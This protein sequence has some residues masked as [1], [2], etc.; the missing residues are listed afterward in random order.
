MEIPLR[1]LIIEDSEDDALLIV[2]QLERAGYKLTNERVETREAA[3]REALERQTW[4]IIISDYKMPRFSGIA[5]LKL[6]KEKGLDIPFIIVSGTIGEEIAAEAM[7]SGAHDYVMKNNLPRLIPAIQRELREAES[8]RERK[9]AEEA[10]LSSEQKYRTLL[11]NASDAIMI[12]DSDGNFLE[13]NKKAEELL[14]YTREEVL[15]LRVSQVHPKEELERVLHA[16]GEIVE[17]KI[18]SL[19]DTKV[20]RKD[21]KTVPVD[22]TGTVIE[23]EGRRV[24]Q[25]IVR[26]I[27][28]RKRAE[29]ALRA[30]EKQY[31]I[32]FEEMD[33]GFCVVE[34]LYGPDGKPVDYRFVEINQAFE[35]HTGLQ[36]ALGKTIRQ[37]V[38]DHDAHW[39]KIYGKVARTGESIRFENPAVASRGIMMCMHSVSAGKIA[40]EWGFSLMTSLNASGPRKP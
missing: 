24:V 17:G 34:M 8:R 23:Y 13:I 1:V 7:V 33:E 2:H 21:G 15:G 27:T 19:A 35:K 37:M 40:R 11:E 9:R 22:I 5:A 28:E 4:D 31:R 6:Y 29:E 10:L 14:G 36:Q 20:L 38:P 18:D 25:G 12:A 30:S 26:D 16:F 32:L 3:M 39:F